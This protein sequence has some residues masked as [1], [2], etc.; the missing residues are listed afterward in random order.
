MNVK[1]KQFQF[2]LGGR[3]D[4]DQHENFEEILKYCCS[5]GIV[6]NLQVPV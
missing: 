5:Q 2:A 1:E 6:P 4:V 3:G